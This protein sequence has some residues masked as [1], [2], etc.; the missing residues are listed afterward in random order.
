MDLSETLGYLLWIYVLFAATPTDFRRLYHTMQRTPSTRQDPHTVCHHR[1]ILSKASDVPIWDDSSRCNK[2][3]TTKLHNLPS[4][5]RLPTYQSL[6]DFCTMCTVLERH[7]QR[8]LIATVGP[9]S[10]VRVPMY[11]HM[12]YTTTL[13]VFER[14]RTRVSMRATHS[15]PISPLCMHHNWSPDTW[16]MIANLICG[17]IASIASV[18]FHTHPYFK[19]KRSM[20]SRDTSKRRQLYALLLMIGLLQTIAFYCLFIALKKMFKP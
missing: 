19:A 9:S 20:L 1:R 13:P 18:V 16:D 14:Y 5:E 10:L 2:W 3:G 7:K 12:P 15:K 11:L 6:P 8:L 4:I 17:V